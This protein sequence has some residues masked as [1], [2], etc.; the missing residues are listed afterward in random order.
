MVV[1]RNKCQMLNPRRA[2]LFHFILIFTFPYIWIH[3]A[4]SFGGFRFSV[5]V[6]W[7][8]CCCVWLMLFLSPNALSPTI[9]SSFLFS[10]TV[11]FFTFISLPIYPLLWL[12]FSLSVF[13]PIIIIIPALFRGFGSTEIGFFPINIDTH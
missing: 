1:L 12:V 10:L 9:I 5:C 3:L 4:G 6:C 8:W 7:C 2:R 13:I 11:F